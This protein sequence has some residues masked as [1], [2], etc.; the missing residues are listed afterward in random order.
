MNPSVNSPQ[1]AFDVGGF[2]P[3]GLDELGQQIPAYEF[4]EFIDRGGM[5]AVYRAKQR[6]LNRMVAV[7]LLPAAF[8]NRR[9]FAERFVREARALAL[10]N[11]PNIVSVYD[12][13]EASEGGCLYYVMEYVKGMN[14]RRFMKEGRGTAKQLLGIAMQVC[15]A[16][17]YAHSKGVVHR[18][19][20]PAN[21]LIDDAGR[22]KVADFGLAK[23]LG[24]APNHL[25]TGTGDA[26]GTP[27]YMAPE[28]VTHEYE[29]D[30]RADIYS[31]GVM[32]YEMLTN[33]VPRGAW[34]MPS[35]AVGVD[36]GFDH[37][38]SRA[39]QTDP[40]RR[41]QSV[42][43]LSSMVRQLVEPNGRPADIPALDRKPPPALPG[44][45]MQASPSATTLVMPRKRLSPAW[46]NTVWGGATV[47]MML[48]GLLLFR[49]HEML[50]T[51]TSEMVRPAL[52]PV[53]E[54]PPEAH[55]QEAQRALA[56]WV[57]DRGGSV[58]VTTREQQEQLMGGEHEIGTETELPMGRFTIWRVSLL[59]VPGFNDQDM[60]RLTDHCAL[61]GSVQN[62]NLAGTSITIKGVQQLPRLAGSLVN[63]NIKDTVA[64]TE[65]SLEPLAALKN[66]QLLR[67]TNST[68]DPTNLDV[69]STVRLI[70]RLR[71]R[72]PE[73]TISEY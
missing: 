24:T 45:S 21:I 34:E 56:R 47:G 44:S 26:L 3:P 5:G 37:L 36:A 19:V 12:S 65:E 42:G 55:S 33:H 14:L 6:N 51:I 60:V 2:Q 23:M 29:V 16:L 28:A 66:L 4:L 22:V 35:R 52:A 53:T 48:L 20:K 40:K 50:Q 49:N 10:L 61:A 32:L 63:L 57:F 58:N 15:E 7:K 68:T 69:G 13:G 73:L 30:H 25:L 9:V 43:D 71:D 54:T 17:Q 1:D 27:D 67:I 38:V 64:L 8:K 39:L 70:A 46:R 72:L 62:L 31:L 41:F 11:H 18:D 59:G